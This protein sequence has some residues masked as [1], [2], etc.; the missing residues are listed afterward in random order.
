M[1]MLDF[2]TDEYAPDTSFE[3]LPPGDYPVYVRAVELKDTKNGTGSYLAVQLVV[4]DGTERG[5]TVYDNINVIN[6]SPTA[7]EIGRRHLAGLL[8]AVGR[9]GERDMSA[10]VDLEC[11]ARVTVKDDPK[12]GPKNRVARYLAA[13]GAAKSAHAATTTTPKTGKGWMR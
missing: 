9:P 10:L 8:A 2:K 5:R 3:P 6:T 12:Y 1:V 11:V 4:V 13:S 7:Q